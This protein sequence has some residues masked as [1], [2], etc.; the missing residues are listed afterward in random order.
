MRAKG[1]WVQVV[2]KMAFPWKTVLGWTSYPSLRLV[3]CGG[4]FN[5]LTG[6]YVENVIVYA[7]EQ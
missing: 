7:T 6:H 3:T 2:A 4:P 5:S 1:T